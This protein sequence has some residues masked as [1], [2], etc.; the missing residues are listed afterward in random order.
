VPAHDAAMVAIAELRG[1][2][3]SDSEPEFQQRGEA[4]ASCRDPFPG[5]CELALVFAGCG[6]AVN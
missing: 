6:I 2:V 1:A 3:E 4:L 5:G